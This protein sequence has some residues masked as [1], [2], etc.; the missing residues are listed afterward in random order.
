MDGL[1]VLNI[2]LH[3]SRNDCVDGGKNPLQQRETHLVPQAPIKLMNI[4]Y[5]KLNRS[6]DPLPSKVWFVIGFFK[7]QECKMSQL[8]KLIY[9]T[10]L[11]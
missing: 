6:M 9:L 4:L 2:L 3:K 8:S 5:G 1:N 7:A 11:F 10:K